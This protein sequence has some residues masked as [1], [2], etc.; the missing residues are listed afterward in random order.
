MW[1]H[2]DSILS[3]WN[4]NV[5][6]GRTQGSQDLSFHPPGI[7]PVPPA[8]EAQ[9]PKPWTGSK[10]PYLKFLE[11]LSY[12]NDEHISVWQRLRSGVGGGSSCVCEGWPMRCLSPWTC[13]AWTL[14]ASVSVSWLWYCC[15]N[16]YLRNQAPH[17]ESWRTQVYYASRPR[18]VNTTSSEPWTK[19]LE[20]FYR[21]TSGQH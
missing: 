7:E 18:G 20:S 4:P 2:L 13:S 16:Q 11:W 3:K 12:T 15:R 17:L 9:S 6:F 1:F 21:Q 10:F 19:G 8:L 5:L 14:A